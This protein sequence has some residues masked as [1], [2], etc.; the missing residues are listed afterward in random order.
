MDLDLRDLHDYMMYETIR[1]GR[2]PEPETASL[3]EGLLKEQDVF[4]DA[5]ANNGFFSL[6]GARRVGPT[7]QVVSFEPAPVTF[8][9]LARNI[10]INNMN[11]V[12]VYRIALGREGG[13]GRLTQSEVESGLNTLVGS[14]ESAVEVR[15]SSLD[16]VLG[17]HKV[18]L[19]KIDVEG[20]ELGVLEGM[21]R[22]IDSNENLSVIIEWNT[23]YATTELFSKLASTFYIYSLAFSSGKTFL[24]RIDRMD[25]IPGF[26]NLLCTRRLGT[27]LSLTDSGRSR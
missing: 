17:S 3:I 11:Q 4:V 9:R 8:T 16:S 23:G 10:V 27:V 26:C 5:G 1:S 12:S 24:R 6:L 2:V 19:V 25:E 14:D 13:I 22:V 21:S 20:S 15:M 18:D 7:G